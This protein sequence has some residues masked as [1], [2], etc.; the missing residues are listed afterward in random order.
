MTTVY[1]AKK[2]K[3]TKTKFSD[4]KGFWEW[5]NYQNHIKSSE[6]AIKSKLST[7]SFNHHKIDDMINPQLSLVDRIILKNEKGEKLN[8]KEKLIYQNYLQ[9]KDNLVNNDLTALK[10]LGLKADVKSDIG[11]IT[12][13]F[14]I[15]ENQ[16]A[17]NNN[18]LVFYIY[19][20][21]VE[22]DIPEEI[23]EKYKLTF[24]K[25]KGIVNTLDRIK[26]Q[27]TKY[28]A[29]MPPLNNQ[30]FVKLDDFQIDVIKNINNNL[31]TIVQAPTSAGKS[32]LTGYLYT[33]K[34]KA[35]VVVPTD[36]LCWQMASMIGNIMK[37][38]I[39]ILTKTHQSVISRDDMI[40]K[41]NKIGII[42][43]TPHE[44]IGLSPLI[45][46]DFDWI[47]IDEIHM[48]GKKNVVRWKV[49]SNFIITQLQF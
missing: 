7:G 31:T 11:R 15:A 21:L 5:N 12:K 44:L 29:N 3:V 48:I 32:I 14:M 13:L 35:L 2:N 10:N 33:K 30:G 22:F 45:S 41:I 36:I 42:V 34:V 17:C 47:V 16:L 28:Y 18:D 46:V 39:P 38:D 4:T 19:Q 40:E 26:L 9:K 8:S 23:L 25:M 20:K 24:E 1:S 27:F 37:T 49:L 6:E 43:G